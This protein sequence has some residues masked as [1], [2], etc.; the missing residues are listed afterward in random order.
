MVKFGTYHG[1]RGI[2]TLLPRL[3]VENV[4][5]VSI[6]NTNGTASLQFGG[7]FFNVALSGGLTAL[8][9]ISRQS[10]RGTLCVK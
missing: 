1:K 3:L 5:L 8:S 9:N 10:S 7:V 2:L 6:Y 4:D